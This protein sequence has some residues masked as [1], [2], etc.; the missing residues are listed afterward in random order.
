MQSVDY[1][2]LV[3]ILLKGMQEQQVMIDELKAEIDELKKNK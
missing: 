2:K 3:P 1:S